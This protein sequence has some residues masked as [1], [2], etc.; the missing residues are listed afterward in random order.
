MDLL[1]KQKRNLIS[2][3][4]QI[5]TEINPKK[6]N[7]LTAAIDAHTMHSMRSIVFV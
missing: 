1:G 4:I 2:A 7:F 3:L 6:S 5:N